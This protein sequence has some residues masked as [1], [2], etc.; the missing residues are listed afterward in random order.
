MRGALGAVAVVAIVAV[1]ALSACTP[2]TTPATPEEIALGGMV[3]QSRG[4]LA[5]AVA[6]ARAGRWDLAAAHAAHPAEMQQA[7]DAALSKHDADA[8]GALRQGAKD[9]VAAAQAKDLA[10]LEALVAEQDARYARIPAIVMGAD[11]VA[12]VSYRASVVATLTEA[13]ANEYGDSLQDGRIVQLTEYQDAYAFLGRAHTIWTDI[14]PEIART[15]QQQHDE[16]AAALADLD[17]ALPG[18][19][20]PA[21]PRSADTVA[22]AAQ[23][24]KTELNEAVSASTG[25]AGTAAFAAATERLD[26]ALAALDKGDAAT[27][28]GEVH[29]FVGAWSAIEATVKARST[30]AYA[31]IEEDTAVATSALAKQP[32]DTTAARAAITRTRDRLRPFAETTASYGPFDAAVILLREGFEALL[33]IAALLAFLEKS[34]NAAKQKWIWAGGT[35]GV[36]ASVAVALV[37]NVAFAASTS[38]GVNRE[39]LEGATGIFAA[40][41]L[42]YMSYWLHSK[43]SISSWQ[44]YIEE[45][46]TSALAR[47]S[48]LSIALIAFLAVFREGAETVLFYLGIAPAI[49]V[50]DLLLG[51]GIGVV[52]LTVL[53]LV[54][55]VFGMRIPIRPFFLVATVLVYYLAFK[56]IGSGIHSLQVAGLVP[57]TSGSLPDIDF[58][59]VFP[60]WETTVVQLTLLIGA[61][62]LLLYE[63]L[64]PHAERVA[65]D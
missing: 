25:V 15:H 40:A 13:V 9:V 33:V 3:E 11:R 36:G 48:L 56:F 42:V 63:R 55:L 5:N 24:V 17:A 37:V 18:L 7:I 51:L 59:G 16:A 65:A 54:V 41:M 32:A 60:T 53:G 12:D 26:T 34:G 43:S 39:I 23:T 4:H 19:D 52:G 62:G 58:F 47:N 61:C 50:G 21:A 45:K 27:A 29:E 20:P 44:R 64:R 35:A 8:D 46:S 28:A 57:T 14:A 22:A 2:A 49:G 6:N 38:A 1:L 30:E 10:R 31:A